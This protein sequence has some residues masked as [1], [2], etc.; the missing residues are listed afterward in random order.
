MIKKLA[1]QGFKLLFYDFEIVKIGNFNEITKIIIFGSTDSISV[2]HEGAQ[3]DNKQYTYTKYIQYIHYTLY[4]NIIHNTMYIVLVH[5][6]FCNVQYTYIQYT[7]M[8][9][10][11]LPHEALEKYYYSILTQVINSF[12]Q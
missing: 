6:T 3:Q 11:T 5:C 12:V 4:M 2:W 7:S 8:A 1:H 10:P 9:I